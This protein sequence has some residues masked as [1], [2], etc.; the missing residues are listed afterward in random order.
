MFAYHIGTSSVFPYFL[1]LIHQFI[2][3]HREYV[4]CWVIVV[5]YMVSDK[6]SPVAL[7]RGSHHT[8]VTQEPGP[9]LAISASLAQGLS[10]FFWSRLSS[11]RPDPTKVRRPLCHR[12][13]SMAWTYPAGHSQSQFGDQTHYSY[14]ERRHADCLGCV[15]RPPCKC[16]SSR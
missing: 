2:G 13:V 9:I 1:Q 10:H 7:H 14:P 3:M 6:F 5:A 4:C 16:P 11:L 12:R 8:A 15:G